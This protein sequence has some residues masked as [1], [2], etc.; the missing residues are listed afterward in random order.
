MFV[1]LCAF[2][3]LVFWATMRAFSPACPADYC[4]ILT[5]YVILGEINVNVKIVYLC[6][7]ILNVVLQ[8]IL[9]QIIAIS[10]RNIYIKAVLK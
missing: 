3:F 8:D 7:T 1:T 6:I 10:S 4:F 9:V 2:Y 5:Y